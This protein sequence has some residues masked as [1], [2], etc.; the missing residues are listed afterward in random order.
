MSAP[1]NLSWKSL[2]R[3]AKYLVTHPRMVW[4][5][6]HQRGPRYIGIYSE[7]NFAGCREIRKSTSGGA[8]CFGIHCIRTW[9]KTQGVIA[10]SSAE[11]EYAA[12]RAG[13]EGLGMITLCAE[14]GSEVRA[15][16]HIDATAAM[17]I[18]ER[19][20]LHKVRHLDV[21]T[22]WLQ[23]QSAKEVLPIVKVSS[24]RNSAD[25]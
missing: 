13:C 11:S 20:G 8:I 25:L 1:T 22:L 5:F 7:A 9:S 3:V 19:R 17:G 21:D 4:K 12:A 6:V 24:E 18:L 14:M 16:L 2:E 10:R 23:Q 15:R